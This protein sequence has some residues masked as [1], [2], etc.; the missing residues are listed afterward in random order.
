[1][2]DSGKEF[3]LVLWKNGSNK[4]SVIKTTDIKKGKKGGFSAKWGSKFYALQVLRQS[5]KYH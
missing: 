5:G 1:M 2:T 4:T 3:A